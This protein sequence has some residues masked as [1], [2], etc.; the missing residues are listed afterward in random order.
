V[1][2]GDGFT[3]GSNGARPIY[4]GRGRLI[5]HTNW[6]GKRLFGDE[7]DASGSTHQH[8]RTRKGAPR[9]YVTGRNYPRPEPY[10]R[11]ARYDFIPVTHAQWDPSPQ[12][13]GHQF[14][15]RPIDPD[16]KQD[17]SNEDVLKLHKAAL[18]FDGPN[19]RSSPPEKPEFK[20]SNKPW[21]FSEDRNGKHTGDKF[22][23]R[24]QVAEAAK[25][26][27][28]KSAAWTFLELLR[29]LKLPLSKEWIDALNLAIRE[30]AVGEVKR[31]ELRTAVLRIIH[32]RHDPYFEQYVRQGHCW[33]QDFVYQDDKPEPQ[34]GWRMADEEYR[35]GEFHCP[36]DFRPSKHKGVKS[37][38]TET[39][40]LYKHETLEQNVESLRRKWKGASP[41]S[42]EAPEATRLS[43]EPSYFLRKTLGIEQLPRRGGKLERPKSPVLS[44]LKRE[45]LPEA[46]TWAPYK[47]A[48][49][50]KQAWGWYLSGDVLPR[51]DEVRVRSEVWKSWDEW[52]KNR[53]F[54]TEKRAAFWT[55]EAALDTLARG[56]T[57]IHYTR[58]R[59]PLPIPSGFSWTPLTPKQR[60]EG[61]AA[62]A[63]IL[64]LKTNKSST[65]KHTVWTADE[66]K[67][68]TVS[69]R[70]C[71]HL[72]G[73]EDTY[74][75]PFCRFRCVRLLVD[76]RP[77]EIRPGALDYKGTYLYCKREFKRRTQERRGNTLPR[78]L[79]ARPSLDVLTIKD[80]VKL[81]DIYIHREPSPLTLC[82]Q[83]YGPLDSHVMATILGG[84]VG[85]VW[86]GGVE[87]LTKEPPRPP[88]YGL[89]GSAHIVDVLNSDAQC[90]RIRYSHRYWLDEGRKES[91][92]LKPDEIAVPVIVPRGLCAMDEHGKHRRLDWH[93]LHEL[94]PAPTL[95]WRANCGFG[96]LP[97]RKPG[98]PPKKDVWRDMA[99][100]HKG[101]LEDAA[102]ELKAFIT[103]NCTLDI[104]RV[105]ERVEQLVAT[106]RIQGWRGSVRSGAEWSIPL[107]CPTDAARWAAPWC[108]PV[109]F[110]ELLS[111]PLA[112]EDVAW[113]TWPEDAT[114]RLKLVW[115]NRV[116][117]WT[118][119]PE[120]AALVW[121]NDLDAQSN[122]T[123]LSREELLATKALLAA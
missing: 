101:T 37:W 84:W 29:A 41:D 106:Q 87:T 70:A 19:D 13:V 72:N 105:R 102:Q 9:G 114:W 38:T 2:Q 52:E 47:P 100:S 15:L 76:F 36:L 33:V 51:G 109:D 90:V 25:A 10:V 121:P 74:R 113:L 73:L 69:Q 11:T 31:A 98:R 85:D 122:A 107:K 108:D 55:E 12:G 23:R 40:S 86:C 92:L 44:V 4:D 83:A 97:K 22:P 80:L 112:S 46:R 56:V 48:A 115:E 58:Y 94:A 116:T 81:D 49:D 7:A 78:V 119:L 28:K 53:L 8:V 96:P 61:R 99:D 59:R 60:Q 66:L 103:A 79:W 20:P 57:W 6:D 93:T 39:S 32:E 27:E 14:E 21:L 75:I 45:G 24:A 1:I 65:W 3:V 64:A 42:Y 110:R 89:R 118:M 50:E 68:L 123:G 91:R 30:F 82:T 18:E 95:I 63:H 34:L 5:G 88:A 17:Y 62:L 104:P 117:P 35:P 16:D 77:D 54:P 111:R 26:A 43:E 67:K 71:L 120:V